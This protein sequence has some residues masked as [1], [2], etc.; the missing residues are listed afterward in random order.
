MKTAAGPSTRKGAARRATPSAPRVRR[1]TS[2]A[3]GR[4]GRQDDDHE[5]GGEVAAEPDADQADE[6]QQRARRVPGHV[7]GPVVGVVGVIRSTYSRSIARDVVD[8][9][10]GAQV[11]VGVG[12]HA[13]DAQPVRRPAPATASRPARRRTPRPAASATAGA[14]R[15]GR[16]TRTRGPRASSVGSVPGPNQIG[17]HSPCSGLRGVRGARPRRHRPVEQPR[18]RS[19]RAARAAC[20]PRAR[21]RERGRAARPGRSCHACSLGAKRDRGRPGP[22]GA[23]RIRKDEQARR[24]PRPS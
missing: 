16:R 22:G 23:S 10:G 1:V 15:A 3:A 13:G 14:P 6:E 21:P 18:E 7:R 5:P 20:P 12:E 17:S 11:L 4:R 2:T 19:R 24:R 8:R 9:A